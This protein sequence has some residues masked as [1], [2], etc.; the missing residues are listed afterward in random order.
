VLAET[1]RILG[2]KHPDTKRARANLTWL[3][4]PEGATHPP[5]ATIEQHARQQADRPG[6]NAG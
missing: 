1:E 2:P 6:Q 5:T 3:S 4:P